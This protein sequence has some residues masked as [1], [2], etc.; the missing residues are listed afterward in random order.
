M[1]KGILLGLTG[2]MGSGKSTA[3]N[4]LS[5]NHG[6]WVVDA[7]QIARGITHLGSPLLPRLAEAFGQDILDQEGRLNRRR[8]AQI[9]FSS[10]EGAER[11][12]QITHPAIKEKIIT[13]IQ[14]AKD[15]GEIRIILDAPLLFES[16]LDSICDRVLSVLA[17]DEI[18]IKRVMKRDGIT[19]EEVRQR[20]ST[21]QE[22]AF[23]RSHSDYIFE[24]N[25]GSLAEQAAALIESLRGGGFDV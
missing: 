6:F 8:L 22:D 23:Y 25:G 3:A 21:Q 10:E 24:N 5:E 15:R 16:G 2:S 20:L 19:E 17:D 14:E 9:A 4:I 13:S 18:K 11:L 12:N 1:K 7:D